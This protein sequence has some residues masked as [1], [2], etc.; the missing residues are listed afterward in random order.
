MSELDARPDFSQRSTDDRMA[1]AVQTALSQ[2]TTFMHP[3]IYISDDPMLEEAPFVLEYR[4]KATKEA[5]T[6]IELPPDAA[7]RLMWM[8][9]LDSG[10]LS[11]KLAYQRCEKGLLIVEAWHKTYID[12]IIQA[13]SGNAGSFIRLLRSIGEADYFGV[14]YPHITIDIPGDIDA[15]TLHYLDHIVW[16]PVPPDGTPHTSRLSFRRRVSGIPLDP[17]E[18]S[19]RIVESFYPTVP[20]DSHVLVLSADVELSPMYFHYLFFNLLEYRYSM[21]N[22]GTLQSDSLAGIS[23]ITPSSHFDT[24]APFSPPSPLPPQLKESLQ[25]KIPLEATELTPFL[26][27]APD[28][29]ATLYFG[30]RWLELHSYLS[31]RISTP[32]TPTPRLLP[33]T[34]PAFAEPLYELMR[35]RGYTILYPNLPSHSIAIRNSSPR[36]QPEFTND[37]ATT[38]PP[39]PLSSDS[40]QPQNFNPYT[41]YLFPPEPQPPLPAHPL[42]DTPLTN[43]LPPPADLPELTSLPLLD[44]IGN[45]ITAPNFAKLALT[46]AA[47]F[48]F[49]VGSCPEDVYPAVV[50]GVADDLFCD[51]DGEPGSG[52]RPAVPLYEQIKQGI[53]SG[54]GNANEREPEVDTARTQGQRPESTAAV[55]LVSE[56][57][58][59]PSDPKPKSAAGPAHLGGGSGGFSGL[60]VG[61]LASP[62][63]PMAQSAAIPLAASALTSNSVPPLDV[64]QISGSARAQGHGLSRI[65]GGSPGGYGSP[66]EWDPQRGRVVDE[67]GKRVLMKEFGGHLERQ[68]MGNKVDREEEGRKMTPAD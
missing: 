65:N 19:M 17:L 31:L 64:S 46:E 39:N 3:H 29:I 1:S 11:G 38:F 18:A 55:G 58:I 27:Q 32:T 22:T 44:A 45:L 34:T 35:L 40:S 56:A 23:L 14:R 15:P 2:I 61:G 62:G 8:T 52:S 47:T 42:V 33:P 5:K 54:S 53:I 10:S 63:A 43:I 57:E 21:Y 59:N 25:G 16:P 13:P 66:K 7:E 24:Q 4:T 48:R 26:W 67:E 41:P 6:L 50:P 68:A 30:N 51:A 49:M 9:R 60:A 28:T 37:A 12:I 36:I 20:L